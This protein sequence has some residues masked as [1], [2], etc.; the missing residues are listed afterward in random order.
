MLHIR[1]PLAAAL[2]AL[3]LATTMT[4]ALPVRRLFAIFALLAG[5]AFAVPAQASQAIDR[6]VHSVPAAAAAPVR[7]ESDGTP[8]LPIARELPAPAVA[9]IAKM[10]SV[11]VLQTVA[12]SAISSASSTAMSAADSVAGTVGAVQSAAMSAASSVASTAGEVQSVARSAAD[13]V[14]SRAGEVQRGIASWYHDRFHD[15]RTASGERYNMNAL[16]AAHPSLPF[17]TR[18]CAHSPATGKS[19]VVRI[20]DRGPFH[21]GRIIDLSKAAA[22]ALGIFATKPDVIAL[23]DDRDERCDASADTP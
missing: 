7:T 18:L 15:R 23:F 17:G 21:G 13:S 4:G 10:M 2:C 19:A 6:F 3:C 22:K 14:V 9:R 8:E 16:T 1:D 11:E 12:S 20:N 5:T